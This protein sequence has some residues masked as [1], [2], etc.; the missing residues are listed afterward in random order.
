[1]SAGGADPYTLVW[2]WAVTVRVARPTTW[3]TTPDALVAYVPV[4]PVKVA[5]MS[6]EPAV[7]E[8]ASRVATPLV[9]RGIVPMIAPEPVSVNVTPPTGTPAPEVTV[10]VR[11]T[12][13]P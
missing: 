10:A 13:A 4:V 2:F 12:D 8:V 11:T 9:F 1:V 6:C 3:V 5:R 7:S